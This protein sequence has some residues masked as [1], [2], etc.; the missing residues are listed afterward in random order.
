MRHH[1]VFARLG[2][3]MSGSGVYEGNKAERREWPF[4]LPF[5]FVPFFSC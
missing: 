1:F 2:G 4:E 5:I 3:E